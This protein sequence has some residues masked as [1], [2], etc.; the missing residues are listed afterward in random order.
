MAELPKL[1]AN[2]SA[3]LAPASVK[4]VASLKTVKQRADF[5]GTLH[6]II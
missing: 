3:L 2:V 6:S 4:A 1:Y 5:R